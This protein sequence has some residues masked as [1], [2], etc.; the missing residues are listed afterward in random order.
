MDKLTLLSILFVVV[1]AVVSALVVARRVVHRRE[2]IKPENLAANLQSIAEKANRG[3]VKLHTPDGMGSDYG[4]YYSRSKDI[5]VG[6]AYRVIC[7]TFRLKSGKWIPSGISVD[8]SSLVAV[9][10]RLPWKARIYQVTNLDPLVVEQVGSRVIANL[11]N[12]ALW[13]VRV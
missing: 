4:V 9:S 13:Q 6:G 11:G 7:Y 8:D 10:P 2:E 5:W 3:D 1:L 12:S